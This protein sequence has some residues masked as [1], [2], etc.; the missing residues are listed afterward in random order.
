MKDN[1]KENIKVPTLYSNREVGK[2]TKRENTN[3]LFKFSNTSEV[4]IQDHIKV[5]QSIKLLEESI[6]KIVDARMILNQ[7]KNI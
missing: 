6:K 7:I 3:L 4:T 1:N 2:N 5:D